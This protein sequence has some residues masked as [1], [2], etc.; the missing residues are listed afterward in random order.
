MK[1]ILLTLAIAST[2][3]PRA[4]TAESGTALNFK[5]H[6]VDDTINA[7]GAD[8]G[9]KGLSGLLDIYACH[10]N[11]IYWY[12]DG[13]KHVID[14]YKEPKLFIHL[15]SADFDKDGDADLVVADHAS[16]HVAIYDNP[17]N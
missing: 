15:R 4:L 5:R 16:G 17:G 2:V 7:L 3:T 10:P 6:V 1:G 11:G 13:K 9:D 12:A 8:V 14:E